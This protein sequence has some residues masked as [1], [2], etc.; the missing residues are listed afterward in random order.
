MRGDAAGLLVG[1][2]AISAFRGGARRRRAAGDR[3]HRVPRAG[4]RLL[5]CSSSVSR[6]AGGGT[7][8][9][10]QVWQR[11]D[12][13]WLITAAHVTPARAGARPVGVAHGRRPALAGRVGGSARR[14]H[15]SRSRT[16]SPIKGY[17]I[18]AGNPT[19]LDDARA[20]R[21]RRRP[22]SPTCCAAG[23]RCAAS[24][25]PTSSRTA[26]PAT[27][28]TTAPRRTARVPGRAPGRLVERSGIR[29]RD[30]PGRRSASPPTPPARSA[31]PRRTRA[32]GGCARRTGWCRGR[33]CCRSR[34]PST[35][36]AGS[37][38]T[39][40]RCSAVVDWCLSYDG[41][42]VDRE[43]ARRVRRR[44]AVALPRARRG[45]RRGRARRRARRS[46]RCWCDWRR[47]TMPPAST[48]VD[49]RAR[50]VLR[51][52]P[53]RAGAPRRG[54]TTATG[55]RAHPDALGPAVAE[56]FAIA[57]DGHR[58]GRGGR[59]RRALEPLRERVH[60]LVADAVLLLPTVPGPG[61]DAH[62]R[63]RTRRRRPRR[64]A[65]DDDA[66]P[67]IGGLPALSRAAAHG[68][69]RTLGPAPVGVCLVGARGHRHRPGA[70][71]PPP[72]RSGRASA[73][74]TPQEPHDADPRSDRPARP[75]AHGPRA[76]SRPYPR[77]LRAM[78]APLVGQY[79]PVMTGVR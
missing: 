51:A 67:A 43:R 56:R 44:P 74:P 73:T 31:C 24:P 76:R 14:A 47:P 32:C 33:G 35:R 63:R 19:C 15:A 55:S 78:S 46:T 61:A 29:G 9:Q 53:H 45:A 20:P 71:R 23:R 72:R 27:T 59:S 62:R 25:A 28:R 38:A 77:V 18:G 49:R 69:R 75:P 70:P 65:A 68:A 3:A 36:S 34:S 41:S 16:C 64:D 10:T 12:G 66:R 26:S 50:R 79:D 1:H 52:V 48:R 37:P 5:R 60:A 57:A 4:R 39:A 11:I 6:F 8:L 13:R 17:R 7:G 58:R 54:A 40:R 2:D 22:R 21:P 42:R 30:R